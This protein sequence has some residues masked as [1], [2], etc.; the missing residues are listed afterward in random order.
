MVGESRLR[1]PALEK[2]RSEVEVCPP[3]PRTEVADHYRWADVF[4]FPSLCE[5]SATVTYEALAHGL[6]VVCTPNTGSVVRDGVE[7]IIVPSG[8][9][10]AIVEAL[11][12]LAEDDGLR[13]AMSEAALARATDHDISSYGTR[14]LAN[15]VP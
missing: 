10:A 15:L 11:V 5:G 7:G 8:D 12:S 1:S 3:V 14:L 9:S 4:L 2:L 6:P 13:L